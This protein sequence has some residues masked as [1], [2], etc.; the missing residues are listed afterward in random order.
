MIT[1]FTNKQKNRCGKIKH[2]ILKSFNFPKKHFE[3]LILTLDQCT[4]LTFIQVKY[5]FQD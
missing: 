5:Q 1:F 2:C 3:K 4:E